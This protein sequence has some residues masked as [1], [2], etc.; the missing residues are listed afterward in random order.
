MNGERRLGER[1]GNRGGAIL[2][3]GA[4]HRVGIRFRGGGA[5]GR[6]PSRCRSLLPGPRLLER[7][8]PLFTVGH[9]FDH[10]GQM[11]EYLRMNGFVPPASQ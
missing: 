6:P 8:L 7:H 11:V 2:I 1:R 9:G 3:A 5:V 4:A 10:Y